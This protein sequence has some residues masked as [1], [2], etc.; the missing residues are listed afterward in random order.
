MFLYLLSLLF[1]GACKT[2]QQLKLFCIFYTIIFKMNVTYILWNLST[3][4]LFINFF[5]KNAK[6]QTLLHDLALYSFFLLL[7]CNLII[8]CTGIFVIRNTN[9]RRFWLCHFPV[10]SFF[11]HIRTYTFLQALI[12]NIK[13]HLR[14]NFLHILFQQLSGNHNLMAAA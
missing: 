12:P 2:R 6:P 9:G 5:I 11:G 7:H 1:R 8:V 10:C 13:T 4:F 3:I 14:I